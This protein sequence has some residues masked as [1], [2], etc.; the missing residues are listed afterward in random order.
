VKLA[1][2]LA[3]LAALLVVPSA[4]A[5]GMNGVAVVGAG[6]RSLTL[7]GRDELLAEL[8]PATTQPAVP[9]GGYLLV[10]PLLAGGLAAEPG[11]F[12]PG[13]GA[14]CFS[15][16]FATG[17]CALVAPA[18]ADSL[19][20][21]RLRAAVVEPTTIVRLSWNGV[22]EPLPSSYAT[23]LELVLTRTASS[24]PA[25]SMRYCTIRFT[26]AW[27][28]PRAASRPKRL[29]VL[30][31]GLYAGGRVYRLTPGLYETLLSAA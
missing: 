9:G 11:R 8:R 26:A 18:L 10:Y 16:T 25:R 17:S 5:K 19:R 24:R 30:A 29:C 21:T 1:A 3:A 23:T 22:A 28:G 13:T 27:R 20:A 6:G 15:W 7:P 12:Y 14:A 2:A 31:T 4:G